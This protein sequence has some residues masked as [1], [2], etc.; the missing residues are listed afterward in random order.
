MGIIGFI[1]SLITGQN[2]WTIRRM[3]RAGLIN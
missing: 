1:T 2:F 3:L